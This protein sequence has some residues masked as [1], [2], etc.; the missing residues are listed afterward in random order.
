MQNIQQFA[1]VKHKFEYR[2]KSMLYFV[3]ILENSD[4]FFELKYLF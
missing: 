4:F 3:G 1:F 2:N